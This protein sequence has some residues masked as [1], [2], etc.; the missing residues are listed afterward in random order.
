M[1][2]FLFYLLKTASTLISER[3]SGRSF[4]FRYTTVEG[5]WLHASHPIIV[6]VLIVVIPCMN[7]GVIH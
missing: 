7:F 2:L 3:R 6:D 1:N 4:M 5:L